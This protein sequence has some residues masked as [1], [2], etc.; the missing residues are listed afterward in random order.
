MKSGGS[1]GKNCL[2]FKTK[3]CSEVKND[4]NASCCLYVVVV[5]V[6]CLITKY[7]KKAIIYFNILRDLKINR[8]FCSQ[9]RLLEKCPPTPPLS[10]HFALSGK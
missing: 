6:S 5:F 7:V 1:L 8:K 4:V 3:Q 10:Q 2:H 9:F